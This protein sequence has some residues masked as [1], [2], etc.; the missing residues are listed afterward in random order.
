MNFSF[1]GVA[2]S[3]FDIYILRKRNLIPFL[4]G[5]ILH[6]MTKSDQKNTITWSDEQKLCSVDFNFYLYYYYMYFLFVQCV[7]ILHALCVYNET[8]W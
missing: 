3:C 4:R 2:I 6:C 1:L 8:F 7:Y 5:P